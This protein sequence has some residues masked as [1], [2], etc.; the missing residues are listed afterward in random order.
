V[1][2]QL[3][4]FVSNWSWYEALADAKEGEQLRDAIFC[5][6]EINILFNAL[7]LTMDVAMWMSV[8]DA[9]TPLDVF[10]QAVTCAAS[11]IATL[12]T[13]FDLWIIRIAA[14]IADANLNAFVKATLFMLWVSG[15]MLATTA[16]TFGFSVTLLCLRAG[17][18][19]SPDDPNWLRREYDMG[20]F[21][22]LPFWTFLFFLCLGVP[23]FLNLINGASRLVAHS[24]LLAHE[25]AVLPPESRFWS[26]EKTKQALTAI[27]LANGDLRELYRY[28]ARRSSCSS[29]R[30][31]GTNDSARAADCTTAP[32]S[33]PKYRA[34]NVIARIRR[35]H[36]QSR[37]VGI[38]VPPT[39]AQVEP[40]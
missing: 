26:P 14:P 35:A 24:G 33:A 13:L 19:T 23:F 11:A 31:S 17:W 12:G 36:S 21:L 3:G 37:S 1:S 2:D 29:T 39:K 9:R 15:Q 7:V 6:S 8:T 25:D 18:A 22:L 27:A 40:Q 5:A 10:C 16:W 30:S 28:E 4:S 20:A 34:G 32:T 38:G